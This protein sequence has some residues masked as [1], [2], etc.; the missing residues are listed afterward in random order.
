[1]TL[2]GLKYILFYLTMFIDTLRFFST[3]GIFYTIS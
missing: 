3:L 2:P 1:M